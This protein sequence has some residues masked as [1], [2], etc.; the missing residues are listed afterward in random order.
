MRR[1][2]IVGA[3]RY[4]P[5]GKRGWGPLR[6]SQYTVD[7]EDYFNRANDN[8][9]VF[10]LVETKEAVENLEVIG[11]V[12]GVDVFIHWYVGSVSI[13]GIEPAAHAAFRRPMLS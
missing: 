3:T 11:G 8:I 4:P 12:P 9:L 2:A 1:Q 5:Q 7:N 6:A 13:N 10:L